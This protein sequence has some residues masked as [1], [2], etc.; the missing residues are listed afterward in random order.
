MAAVMADNWTLLRALVLMDDKAAGGEEEVRRPVGGLETK[1]DL[2]LLLVSAGLKGMEPAPPVYPCVLG[3][4][5]IRWDCGD[6]AAFP[7]V[8]ERCCLALFCV[9]ALPCP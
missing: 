1:V 2:L 8:G 5:Y 4:Q 9:P 3:G 7:A 6:P